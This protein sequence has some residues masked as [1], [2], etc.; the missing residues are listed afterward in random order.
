MLRGM[1]TARGALKKQIITR[2]GDSARIVISIQMLNIMGIG[3]VEARPRFF[4]RR[5]ATFGASTRRSALLEEARF[6]EAPM[7]ALEAPK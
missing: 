7:A 1:Q 5:S 3:V 2:G 4:A 6:L